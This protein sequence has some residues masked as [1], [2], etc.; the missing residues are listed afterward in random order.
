MCLVCWLFKKILVFLFKNS[1]LKTN[2]FVFLFWLPID[3]YGSQVSAF[4]VSDPLGGI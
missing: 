3:K 4:T 1:Y 2:Y